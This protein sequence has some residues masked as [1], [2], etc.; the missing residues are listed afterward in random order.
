MGRFNRSNKFN[1]DRNSGP[2]QKYQAVCSKC[3]KDCE[4]PFRPSG[5]R[6]VF[7]SDCF[8]RQNNSRPNNFGGRSNFGDKRM[9]EATCAKCG[10]NCQVPFQPRPGKDVFCNACFG[11]SAP[12]G[13]RGGGGQMDNKQLEMLNAKLDKI[14]KILAPNS[15]PEIKEEKKVKKEKEVKPAKKTTKKKK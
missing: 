3:G 6:P 15:A 11:K 12:G 13:N 7:C 8:G 4:L 10:Q 1:N 2:S 5:D 14:L 9:F